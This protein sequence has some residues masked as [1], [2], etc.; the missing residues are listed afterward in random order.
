MVI[1]LTN[2][3]FKEVARKSWN[4]ISVKVML[5]R[6]P[7]RK[8]WRGIGVD[9][10]RNFGITTLQGRHAFIMHGTLPKAPEQWKYGIMAFDIMANPK[11]YEGTGHAIVEGAAFKQPYG[12]A[13][14]AYVRFGFVCGLYYA[15]YSVD[16]VPPA[17]IRKDALGHGRKTGLQVWPELNPNAADSFAA[18]LYA[19]GIRKED[20]RGSHLGS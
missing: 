13:N 16:I 1:N 18:A 17:T 15:G 3:E 6:M 2:L 20:V 5:C 4:G 11:F 9:P 10:G 12:E 7:G 14:L 8:D 19:A